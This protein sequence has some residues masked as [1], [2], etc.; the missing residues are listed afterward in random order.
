MIPKQVAGDV[1]QTTKGPNKLQEMVRQTTM[2]SRSLQE[3]F[4]GLQRSK[5]PVL[6]LSVDRRRSK[7]G[8]HPKI[9]TLFPVDYSFCLDHMP[10]LHLEVAVDDVDGK[11]LGGGQK[12]VDAVA[13]E[14]VDHVLLLGDE[15]VGYG[16]VEIIREMAR[17]T[18]SKGR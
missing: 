5:A 15:F 11:A 9:V 7:T 14:L 18:L 10:R 3:M 4:V 13:L 12:G 17:L 1:R 16:L 2:I 6:G 8:F